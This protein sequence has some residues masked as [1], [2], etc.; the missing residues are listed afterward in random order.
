MKKIKRSG[1]KDFLEMEQAISELLSNWEEPLIG[2]GDM[3]EEPFATI[4]YLAWA[5]GRTYASGEKDENIVP[6]KTR[7]RKSVI[8]ITNHEEIKI[9]AADRFKEVLQRPEE[10]TQSIY[11]IAYILTDAGILADEKYLYLH[12]IGLKRIAIVD[13][14]IE[15]YPPAEVLLL[16]NPAVYFSLP[17]ETESQIIFLP[18]SPA[19]A[20]EFDFSIRWSQRKEFCLALDNTV[21]PQTLYNSAIKLGEKLKIPV[22]TTLQKETLRN[23]NFVLYPVGAEVAPTYIPAGLRSAILAGCV[24]ISNCAGAKAI[25]TAEVSWDFHDNGDVVALL[26]QVFLERKD[27]WNIEQRIKVIP[28][29]L[30]NFTWEGILYKL[31]DGGVF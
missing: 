30:L 20:S 26:M 5:F 11:N 13:K 21:L 29:L 23:Y 28:H 6:P 24:V 3:P 12:M 2:I 8:C 9:V 4:E 22:E 7:W 17:D 14:P 15:Q 10:C 1:F 27:F 18:F 25:P 31:C 19:R 16:L